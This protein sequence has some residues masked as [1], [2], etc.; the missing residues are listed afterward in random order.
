MSIWK[1]R[2]AVTGTNVAALLRASHIKPWRVSDNGERLD[3][4]NGLLLVANLDAA[5]D[6]R[7]VSF[8]DEG[9]ILSSPNLGSQTVRRPWD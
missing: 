7:L 2:C 3:P 8:R 5:F 9:T 4:E 1:G 6:A